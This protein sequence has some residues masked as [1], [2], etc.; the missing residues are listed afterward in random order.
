VIQHARNRAAEAQEAQ[1]S[2]AVSFPAGGDRSMAI[3]VH[4]A[5]MGLSVCSQWDRALDGPAGSAMRYD[6]PRSRTIGNGVVGLVGIGGMTVLAAFLVKVLGGGSVFKTPVV[7]L[8][9]LLGGWAAMVLSFWV[10]LLGSRPIVVDDTGIK[11][12]MFGTDRIAVAWRSI[13]RIEQ[14]RYYDPKAKR[15]RTLFWILGGRRKIEIGDNIEGYQAL[16]EDIDAHIRSLDLPA[17]IV[18]VVHRRQFRVTVFGNGASAKE[19]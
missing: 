17:F 15:A 9:L 7:A 18:D 4:F 2:Q 16:I 1:A 11:A 5:S 3:K 14:R 8:V 12:L 6:Y 19:Q 10:F 13:T